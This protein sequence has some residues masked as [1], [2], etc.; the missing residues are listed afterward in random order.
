MMKI[1]RFAL[2]IFTLGLMSLMTLMSGCS[3]TGTKYIYSPPTSVDGRVCVDE[4]IQSKMTCLKHCNRTDP[5]CIE[6]AED[7]AHADYDAYVG[8]QS[9]LNLPLT[10]TL[11]S[12]HHLEQCKS[13]GC[14]CESDYQVC[15][16]L[17]GTRTEAHNAIAAT[18]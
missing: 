10:K 12:F 15:Y 11:Q 1:Q 3:S 17:C 16:Q 7:K 14:A 6:N 8:Q 5:Q 9:Q 2:V 13:T 4:C 18:E